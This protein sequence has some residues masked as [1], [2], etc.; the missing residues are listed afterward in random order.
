MKWLDNNMMPGLRDPMTGR[1]LTT[2]G[3]LTP[4]DMMRHNDMITARIPDNFGSKDIYGMKIQDPIQMY[5]ENRYK[6]LPN[7]PEMH[8]PLID[9]KPEP[10][11]PNFN[12]TKKPEV[13]KY[14]CETYM[15]NLLAKNRF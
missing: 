3:G 14:Y 11:L 5:N 6:S 13:K 12:L 1:T 7:L 15:D 9:F 4:M 2:P 10:I 8:K